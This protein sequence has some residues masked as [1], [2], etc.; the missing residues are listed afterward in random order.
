MVPRKL[1]G[2]QFR[3]YDAKGALG[4]KWFIEWREGSKR[5]KK[6]GDINSGVTV[7]DRR[8]LAKKLMQ[9][10]R[11][12]QKRKVTQTETAIYRIVAAMSPGWSKKTGQDYAS[13]YKA[14]LSWLSG[15][16]I[17]PEAMNDFFVHLRKSKHQTTVNKYRTVL[18]MLFGKLVR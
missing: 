2:P 1:I 9:E 11:R 12:E 8:K 7:G 4:K 10:L 16:E 3:L 14:L 5:M 6:Y 15:D 18:K 17:T 13:K